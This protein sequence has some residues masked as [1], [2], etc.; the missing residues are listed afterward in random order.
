M[1]RTK[2]AAEPAPDSRTTKAQV[3]IALLRREEGATIAQLCA[4]VGWLP[5]SVRGFMA[6]ALRK[7]HGLRVVVEVT[8]EGRIYRIADAEGGDQ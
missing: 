7:R 1:T 3:L 2:R 4:A 5:H 6:G 8:G